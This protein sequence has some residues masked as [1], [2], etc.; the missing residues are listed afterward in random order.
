MWKKQ[1]WTARQLGP[2]GSSKNF[3][4]GGKGIPSPLR[5]CLQPSQFYAF[6]CT[7]SSQDISTTKVAGSMPSTSSFYCIHCR[8]RPAWGLGQ[9][10]EANQIQQLRI[11]KHTKWRIHCTYHIIWYND[12]MFD[13]CSSF[14]QIL[15][16]IAV[17]F[18]FAFSF[19]AWRLEA[20]KLKHDANE[21]T[22]PH[23][24]LHFVP[25]RMK[26]LETTGSL[27]V[28]HRTYWTAIMPNNHRD[29]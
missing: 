25:T 23:L 9:E 27:T 16:Q 13:T 29:P 20:V 17:S 4:L 3:G 6:F 15:W 8:K 10:V 1:W 26:P 11:A 22:F 28:F 14:S 19:A 18:G 21:P 24:Q 2:S 7:R 12:V 5:Q